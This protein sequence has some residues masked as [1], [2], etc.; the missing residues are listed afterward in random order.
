MKLC[1]LIKSDGYKVKQRAFDL[2][3]S[4][5]SDIKM[6][7]LDSTKLSDIRKGGHIVRFL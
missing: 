2:T 6:A 4:F 1:L 5:V 3:I 7:S